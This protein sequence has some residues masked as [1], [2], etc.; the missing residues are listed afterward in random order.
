MRRDLDAEC[1]RNALGQLL[2]EYKG[3][4]P[5]PDGHESIEVHRPVAENA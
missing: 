3:M 5:D 2:L 1:E 4:I